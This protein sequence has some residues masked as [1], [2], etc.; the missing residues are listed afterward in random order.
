[1]PISV[2]CPGCKARFNVSD[3][4]AGKKGPCPKCKT[5]L[6]VPAAPAEEVKIHVPEEYASGGK[7]SK[8]RL[9]GKPIPRTETKLQPVLIT[10]I[11][12]G[13]LGSL[14]ICLAARSLSRQAADHRRRAGVSLA[15]RGRGRLFV[16][17]RGRARAVSRPRRCGFGPRFAASSTRFCGVSIGGSGRPCRASC[18]NGCWWRRRS[19]ASAALAALATFDLDLRLGRTCT[20]ASIC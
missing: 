20:I 16:F 15:R 17:A 9:V 1:M 2:V 3:K 14:V 18:T 8:G 6:T 11:V 19:S 5:V 10:A 13:V 7:D 12:A 4:F